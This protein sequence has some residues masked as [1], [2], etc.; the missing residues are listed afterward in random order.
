MAAHQRQVFRTAL[1]L[2][3]HRED[4]KDASQEVFLRLFTHLARIDARRPLAPWLYRVTINVCRT[5]NKKRRRRDTLPHEDALVHA[6]PRG[7]RPDVAAE[8]AEERDVAERGLDTLPDKERAAVVLRDIE[9]LSTREVAAILGSAEV[10]VRSQISRARVKLKRF[11]D[12]ALK[13]G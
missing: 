13:G 3:G 8:L 7:P 10:T 6:Q 2:L 12:R 9:G 1:R 4:A 5:M 11:R